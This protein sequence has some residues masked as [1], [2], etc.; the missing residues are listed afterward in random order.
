M[1]SNF[2]QP[3]PAGANPTTDPVKSFEEQLLD[4]TNGLREV[5][6]DADN[7]SILIQE[8]TSRIATL[9]R[10]KAVLGAGRREAVSHLLNLR[11][12]HLEAS[13]AFIFRTA[14]VRED[15]LEGVLVAWGTS[16]TTVM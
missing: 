4:L 12:R 2:P 6:I 11:T 10:E 16:M 7:K 8:L 1:S 9:E 5:K 14:D 13:N 15:D 3:S